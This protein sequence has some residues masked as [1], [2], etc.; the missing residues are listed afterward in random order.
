MEIEIILSLF[1]AIGGLYY[2]NY[3]LH[4][5]LAKVEQKIDDVCKYVLNGNKK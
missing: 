3:V 2:F 5:R 4:G 1:G